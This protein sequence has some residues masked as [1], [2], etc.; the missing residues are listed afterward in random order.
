[1]KKIIICTIFLF[2]IVFTIFVI[3]IIETKNN[4]LYDNDELS[5]YT[6]LSDLTTN[7][8]DERFEERLLTLKEV[9]IMVGA[10]EQ[11]ENGYIGNGVTVAIIDSGIYPHPDLT[12]PDNKIIAFKD[13]VNDYNKPY[14]DTGH[15][16]AIAGIIAGNGK[17]D[18]DCEGIAPGIN[19]VAVKVL[20][21]HNKANLQRLI[22]GIEWVIDNKE[23]FNILIMN[24]SI[25]L[26]IDGSWDINLLNAV[27]KKAIDKG[28]LIITSVGNCYTPQ[29]SKKYSPANI[30]GVVTVG[31]ISEMQYNTYFEYSVANFSCW[32]NSDGISKPDLVAP[33]MNILTL[34]SDLYYKG[35]NNFQMQELKNYY[36]KHTG[37]SQATAV[38][39]GVAAILFEKNSNATSQ[40]IIQILKERCF[41]IISPL[42]QQGNGFIYIN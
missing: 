30:E 25:S 19:I 20:D 6:Q 21:K 37:T 23:V 11:K 8:E 31:A 32:W 5:F 2:V 41:K 24:I 3:K 18:S 12:E 33:G 14:D 1:M 22:E 15:G 9:S 28:I 10:F 16:T 40:E 36:I 13:F 29:C 7:R 38:V 35:D 34:K 26:E 17:V 42:E 4:I 39:S 27:I